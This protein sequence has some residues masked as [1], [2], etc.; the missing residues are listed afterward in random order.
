MFP[1]TFLVMV[2]FFMLDYIP[3]C[4]GLCLYRIHYASN[5]RRIV[6]N[7]HIRVLYYKNVSQA[8]KLSINWWS[9][10]LCR[11]GWG[12]LICQ[13]LACP[14]DESNENEDVKIDV[15]VWRRDRTINKAI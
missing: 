14:E 9:N 13:E 2:P 4:H 7:A 5:G 1:V 15:L 12:V 11:M 6:M 3:R 10:Q 8:L